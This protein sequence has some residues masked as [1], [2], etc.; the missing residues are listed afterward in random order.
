MLLPIPPMRKSNEVFSPI[1]V[2]DHQ[3]YL[4]TC[5]DEKNPDSSVAWI[6]DNNWNGAYFVITY[7]NSDGS[8][9][10]YVEADMNMVAAV[11]YHAIR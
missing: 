1:V 4:I 7:S 3:N 6:G 10:F 9:Y 5:T 11:L 2:N 8:I